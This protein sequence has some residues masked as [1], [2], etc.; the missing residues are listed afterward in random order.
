MLKRSRTQFAGKMPLVRT[1]GVKLQNF[2]LIELLVVI[3]IITILAAILLP[4]L[5]AARERGRATGCLNN[6]KQFNGLWV[7]YSGD[8]DDVL[9]PCYLRTGG[10]VMD[11]NAGSQKPHSWDEF[12]TKSTY[13]G[14]GK[15]EPKA[16]NN[17]NTVFIHPL[18][19][20]PTGR[21]RKSLITY[22]RFP[23][24][25]A[26]AYNFWFNSHGASKNL[27]LPQYSLS[28]MSQMRES[29]KTMVL[30]DDWNRTSSP[31]AYR[32]YYSADD[33]KG[34]A[35]AL[36]KVD[37][38]GKIS[39]GDTGAHGRNANMLFADGHANAQDFFYTT[40]TY[41]K[42]GSLIVWHGTIVESRF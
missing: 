36:Q 3:A 23:M 12:M 35:H 19:I 38:D 22:N 33:C 42:A 17:T 10:F 4:T 34:G 5:Q 6:M 11:A 31:A 39:I 14:R 29:A 40:N 15:A 26:Y 41:H 2:T 32:G 27:V 7:Q 13:M 37:K 28:K 21:S 1:C 25:T 9:L 30:V 16:Y 20:C 18:L 24:R 8:F